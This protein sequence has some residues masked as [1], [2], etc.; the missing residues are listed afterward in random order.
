MTPRISFVVPVR[1]EAARLDRCLKS[2]QGTVGAARHHELVVVDH[3]STDASVEIARRH[4]ATV[5]LVPEPA[6]VSELR[7]RG[8][9]SAT[10]EILAFVDA[11]NEIASGWTVAAIENLAQP[12]V[13]AVGALYLAPLDGTWVQRAYGHLRGRPHG[14]HDVEWLGSGNV[15]V[16]REAFDAVGGFDTSLETCED[17]DFCQKLRAM[18]DAW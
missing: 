9:R 11:D 12:A 3:G 8:A 17:V 5:I 16:W 6:S 10:G 15:A 2:I 4:G 7:N 13:A 14:Q 1:N 18:G